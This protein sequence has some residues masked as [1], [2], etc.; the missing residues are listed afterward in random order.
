MWGWLLTIKSGLSR[1]S[2]TAMLREQLALSE[3]RAVKLDSENV[4]LKSQVAAL[5]SEVKLANES[6]HQKAEQYERLQK[7]HEEEIRIWRT[8]EFRRGK[9]TFGYWVAFCPK[10]KMPVHDNGFSNISCSGNCGWKCEMQSKELNR[11]LEE[12]EKG[13]G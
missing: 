3:S 5:S 7:E 6:L 4:D 2:I 8:V 1:F 12:L 11:C 13:A 9:R 10:C